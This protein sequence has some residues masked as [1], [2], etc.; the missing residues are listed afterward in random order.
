MAEL[1]AISGFPEDKIYVLLDKDYRK[2]LIESSMNKL[3]VK[4][5]FELSLWIN[6]N[7][8]AKFNGGDI[9]YWIEGQRLD[10]RTGKIHPKFIPLWLVLKLVKVC[11]FNISQLDTRVLSYRSG[12]KGL[13]INSPIL[14]IKVT[15]ELD[16]IIIHLFGDGAAGDFTPSYT[17]KN[18]YGVDN[19]IKKLE[20]CFGEFEQ[21]RYFTQSKHQVKFPKAITDILSKYYSIQSYHTHESK[22]PPLIL[23]HS[24]SHKLASILSFIIDEGCIRDV[25]TLYSSNLQLLAG[26]R[27]LVLDCN[28]KCS[29]IKEYPGRIYYSFNLSNNNLD[30]IEKD[31][32]QLS[33]EFLT[34]GLSFKKKEFDFI[35]KRTKVKNPKDNKITR[36]LILELLQKQSLSARDI[37][38]LLGYAYC[39]VIHTLEKLFEEKKVARSAKDGKTYKWAIK[40]KD[41]EMSRICFKEVINLR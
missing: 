41:L 17:Q 36:Q 5:Y 33:K 38:R 7:S 40:E 8:K 35:L 24:K 32:E 34:C 26:V 39:T 28:Y 23:S 14:P 3:K 1:I 4:S 22:I 31:I 27:N 10:E 29:A 2:E 15:P 19:F 30:K 11:N 25:I 13:I 12:G 37:S 21:S 18:K 16:S 20:N 6:K 9:K